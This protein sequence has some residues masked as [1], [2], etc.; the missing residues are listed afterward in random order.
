MPASYPQQAAYPQQ[1]PPA[2]Q[3]GAPYPETPTQPYNAANPSGT[4]TR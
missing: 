3:A 4:Y 2:S 1:Q